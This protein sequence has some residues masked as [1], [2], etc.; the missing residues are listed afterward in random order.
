V[1]KQPYELHTWGEIYSI[2]TNALVNLCTNMK[3]SKSIQRMSK[4]LGNKF[5]CEIYG[6][7]RSCQHQKNRQE[8]SEKNKKR[9]SIEPNLVFKASF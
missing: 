7:R 4:L 3:V 1:F 6:F 5:I 2:I 9:E 8:N